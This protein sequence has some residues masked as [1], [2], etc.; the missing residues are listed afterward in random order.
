[1]SDE[2]RLMPGKEQWLRDMIFF[3]LY[4]CV[5]QT[6]RRE[7]TEVSIV[8]EKNTQKRSNVTTL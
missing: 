1:M 3:C 6:K 5:M 7:K 8:V 4:M 2:I